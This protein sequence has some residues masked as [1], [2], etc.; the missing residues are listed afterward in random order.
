[1]D[2]I[3]SKIGLTTNLLKIIAILAMTMDH[4]AIEFIM[5]NSV[6]YQLFRVIG[7]LTIV[8]MCY[9][10]AEGYY[11]THNIKKY[12][13][14][15]FIFAIVSHVP[16]VF[17]NTGKISLFFGENKFQTSVMWSLFLGLVSLCIWNNKSLKKL[18]KIILLILICILVMPGDWNIFSVLLILGFGIFYEN[19][20]MQI[21]ILGVLSMFIVI[22]SVIMNHP[23]YKEIFLFGLLF[24][25][26]IL[27]KYNGC[28]GKCK[29][30]KWIF[31]V[32]YPL[33]MVILGIIAYM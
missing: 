33:H 25:I 15:L 4:I 21:I 7:R 8:I 29:H 27:L 6:I 9:M 2:C 23:W 28:L 13:T 32:Y 12:L 16:F 26:P 14:R 24:T 19:R 18:Y 1:M 17:F 22:L 30:I 10:V 31:Y 5:P 20:K 3:S 11:H